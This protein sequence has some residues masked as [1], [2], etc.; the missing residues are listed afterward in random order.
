LVRMAPQQ[1]TIQTVVTP[2]PP[3]MPVISQA[4]PAP[5][6]PPA[7][8]KVESA[9]A[10]GNLLGLFSDEDYPASAQAAGAE[11]SAQ[12]QLTIG[13]DGRVVGCSLVKSTG[14]GALDAATCNILRRR[15]KF[16]PAKDSNGNATTDTVTTPTIVWRLQG[17]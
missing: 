5:P 17:E 9:H 2:A 15:A 16:T 1:E 4:P 6:P 11:G 10:K 13:T 12:A 3:P 7:P 8:R 14:N